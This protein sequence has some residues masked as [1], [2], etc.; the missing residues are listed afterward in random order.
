MCIETYPHGEHDIS[1]V[2]HQTS[3]GIGWKH[4]P[5]EVMTLAEDQHLYN[6]T[7]VHLFWMLN[8][9]VTNITTFWEYHY[10]YN[11]LITT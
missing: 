7:V 9:D 10:W 2:T 3:F 1:V 6:V 8:Q 4:D 5:N 11:E